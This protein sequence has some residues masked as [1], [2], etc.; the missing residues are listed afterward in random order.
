[1]PGPE[2]EKLRRVALMWGGSLGPAGFRR[3]V[4]RFG[5]TREVLEAA[6]GELRDPALR[7]SAEQAGAIA[8]LAGELEAYAGRIAQLERL[9]IRVLCPGEGDYPALW[10]E[11]DDAPPV[12][13]LSGRLLPEDD[14]AVALVG[15]RT[16]T[17]E[18]LALSQELG[19]AIAREGTTVVSGLAR[20]C[21]TAAHEGALEGGGRTVAVLGSGILAI[22]PRENLDLAREITQRGAVVSECEPSAPPTVGRLMA[23]NRLTSGLARGVIVVQARDHGGALETAQRGR[24]QGRLVWAVRWPGG[25]AEGAGTASLLAEGASELGDARDAGAVRLALVDHLGRLRL[26]PAKAPEQLRLFGE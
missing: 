19:A 13:C 1:M 17:R 25:L 3:L 9:A 2:R 20:G 14:P 7:L 18:G 6:P 21:D 5:G 16:P 4:Q 26:A 22:H 15:T 24:T 12:V 10:A 8:T 11:L 23:R